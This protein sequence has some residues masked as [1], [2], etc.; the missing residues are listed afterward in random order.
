MRTRGTLDNKLMNDF[1]VT[2]EFDEWARVGQT[3]QSGFSY[4]GAFH[5]V[6]SSASGTMALYHV[7]V[8]FFKTRLQARNFYVFRMDSFK[9]GVLSVGAFVWLG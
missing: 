9:W 2:R 6:E 4:P 8:L 3:Y 7:A 1:K 5:P